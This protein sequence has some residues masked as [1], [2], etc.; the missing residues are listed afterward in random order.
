MDVPTNLHS[1][2]MDIFC[3]RCLSFRAQ[4]LCVWYEVLLPNSH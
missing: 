4:I 2:L 1:L 3:G